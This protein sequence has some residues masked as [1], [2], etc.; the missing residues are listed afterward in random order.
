MRYYELTYIISPDMPELELKS[1]VK[2]TG[3]F[4]LE[5]GGKI[6]LMGEPIRKRL[7]YNIKGKNEAF[8]VT[9]YFYLEPNKLENVEKKIKAD[10]EILRHI[11]LSQK[12]PKPTMAAER[13]VSEKPAAKPS[14][15]PKEHIKEPQK[16]GLQEIDKELEEILKD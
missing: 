3:N 12:V 4:I 7:A 5:E 13:I 2:K 11:L 6:E 1:S 15:K 14:E 16:V 8:L 9:I 10:N